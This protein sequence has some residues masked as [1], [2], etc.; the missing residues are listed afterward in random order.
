MTDAARSDL[1]HL[2]R[3][4]GFGATPAQLDAA[5]KAGYAATVTAL[6]HASEGAD[7][8]VAATPAPQFDEP[9]AIGKSASAEERKAHNKA[10]KA[11]QQQ[12]ALWWLRRM[13]AADSPFPEKMTFFWH[14]HFATAVQKVRSSALM[15]RQNELFRSQGLGTFDVL[16][17]AVAKDPAMMRWLDTAQDVKAHANENFARENMELFTLGYGNYSENDVREAAR[18]FTGWRFNKKTDA[19]Q[20]RPALHDTGS[21]T[22]LGQ[23]G[24]FDGADVVR[25]LCHSAAS[26][27][28]IPTRVWSRFAQTITSDPVV[29]KLTTAYGATLDLRALFSDAFTVPEFLQTKGKL[30]KQPVEYV[31]GALRALGLQPESQHLAVLKNLGQ[32]PFSPPNVGGWTYDDGWLSTAAAYTRLQ[33]AQTAARRGDLALVEDASGVDRVDAVARLLSLDGFGDQSA[34]A[35]QQVVGNPYQLVTLALCSPEYVVN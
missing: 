28:W 13:V 3:R 17:L 6:I 15:L 23:T 16:D 26:K 29:I 19:F 30:V 14:G 35:L 20:E 21:K 12:L 32:V 7:K 18:C 34:K 11:E 9:P 31:V 27:S 4:A 10:L 24:N 5:V 2:Y 1:A 8:G 33:F 25:I 22:V